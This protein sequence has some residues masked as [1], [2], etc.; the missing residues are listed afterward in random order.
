[1]PDNFERCKKSIKKL[2]SISQTIFSETS[3][4]HV[5]VS[6]DNSAGKFLPGERKVFHQC[7]EKMKKK[8]IFE[9]L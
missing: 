3:Y 6:F 1:M 7:Q 8:E 5:E 4:G 2:V 9:K